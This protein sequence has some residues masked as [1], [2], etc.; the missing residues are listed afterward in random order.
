MAYL[1]N[2]ADS[3]S[4]FNDIGYLKFIIYAD[5]MSCTSCTLKEMYQWNSILEKAQSFSTPLKTYFIFA[6]KKEN[7]RNL[8]ITMKNIMPSI[9][10]FI[11]TAGIFSQQN[12]HIPANPMLHTFLLDKQNKVI[13]I[14]DPSKDKNLE[15][16]FWK[17]IEKQEQDKCMP[18]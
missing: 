10:I 11:D 9:P 6:P 12:P 18:E 13:F 7:I 8:Y 2:K 5:S 4:Y 16:I 3:V 1:G 15:D 14:G 17:S